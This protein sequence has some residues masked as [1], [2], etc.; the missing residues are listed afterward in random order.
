MNQIHIVTDSTAYIDKE[1]VRQHDMSV[2]PLYYSFEGKTEKEGFPGE[3][4]DF[5]S[6]LA[7]SSDFPTTSQPSVGD[8][9]EVFESALKKG[10][11]VIALTI[12]S[13]LSGTYNSANTA[14]NLIGSDKISIIDSQTTV[15]N[16]RVLTEM[17]INL[18]K[19]GFSR[20]QIVEKIEEQKTR[21]GIRLTVGTLEY[22]KRGGRLTNAQAVIG[23]FLNVKPIIALIDGKLEAIA[24]VRGKKKAMEKI[25]E[26]IPKKVS[27]INIC[28]IFALK[29]AHEL[30]SILKERYPHAI[31]N[32]QEIGPVIGSH[33]GPEALGVCYVY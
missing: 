33:L 6:R 22:L 2:V 8:F 31:I 7:R 1:F 10:K 13:K 19:Q 23:S 21:M 11:E 14:A 15:A 26:D 20:S 4:Q 30:K 5:F 18:V 29:E 17:A 24:K 28:Q 3:F 16:L 32:I 25:I 9:K 12:S 27:I